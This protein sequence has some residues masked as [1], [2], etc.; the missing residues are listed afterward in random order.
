MIGEELTF[1]CSSVDVAEALMQ[2]R[3]QSGRFVT[4]SVRGWSMGHTLGPSRKIAVK[5]FSRPPR[6]GDVVLMRTRNGFI[7]HRIVRKISGGLFYVTKGDNCTASDGEAARDDIL[8]LV[9][10]IDDG[11]I[12]RN[13]WHWRWP[14]SLFAALL[15]RCDNPRYL[16]AAHLFSRLR[17][18]D[19]RCRQLVQ[20]LK[21]TCQRIK[22]RTTHG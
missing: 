12:I 14:L 17:H 11:G 8:G 18:L 2:V 15:S 21:K 4:L 10:G 16:Q 3:F 20:R 5:P 9:I 13:P 6:L 19:R 22:W 1:Q 7:A